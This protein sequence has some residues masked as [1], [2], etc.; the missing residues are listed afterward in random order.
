MREPIKGDDGLWY[1]DGAGFTTRDSATQYLKVAQQ[2]KRQMAWAIAPVALTLIFLG[3]WWWMAST[4]ESS[5]VGREF[6]SMQQ[7]LDFVESDM[8]EPLRVQVDKPGDVSGKGSQSGRFFRCEIQMTGTRGPV[9][10]GRWD[11]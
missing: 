3:G 2:G 11:R 5:R 9:L 10:Q 7:C 8:G 6:A 1:V 4:K